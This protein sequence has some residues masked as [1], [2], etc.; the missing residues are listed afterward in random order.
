MFV[1]IAKAKNLKKIVWRNIGRGRH[2]FIHSGVIICLWQAAFVCGGRTDGV[3]SR[4]NLKEP[5]YHRSLHFANKPPATKAA[6]TAETKLKQNSF[7]P[8]YRA[9]HYSAKRGLA[10]ACRPSV[11]P[12]VTLVDCDNICWKSWKRIARTI[13]LT[14]SLFVAQ[15]TPTY[16]QG[17]MRKFWGGGVGKEDPVELDSSPTLWR[18]RRGTHGASRGHVH[19]YLSWQ[20][21]TGLYRTDRPRLQ[22]RSLDPGATVHADAAAEVTTIWRFIDYIIISY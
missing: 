21:V 13:S 17:N 22:V 1:K 11:C 4:R 5:I 7:I 9:M 12:A 18:D 20:R 10:I 6:C 14:L 3:A 8:V 2:S 16:S 15:R 19:V